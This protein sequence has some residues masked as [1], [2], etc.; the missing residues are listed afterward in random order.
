MCNVIYETRE[1]CRDPRA[2]GTTEAGYKFITTDSE[3]A[4]RG[5]E[6][7]RIG[8]PARVQEGRGGTIGPTSCNATSDLPCCIP[9]ITGGGRGR[10]SEGWSVEV[11]PFQL[12]LCSSNNVIKGA[13]ILNCRNGCTWPTP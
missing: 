4:R 6:L 1:E 11:T 3:V 5:G 9:W 10:N 13:N 2:W 8:L 12:C 7:Q